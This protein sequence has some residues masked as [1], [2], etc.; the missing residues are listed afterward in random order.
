LTLIISLFFLLFLMFY[1]MNN[2][3]YSNQKHVDTERH[4]N[5]YRARVISGKYWFFQKKIVKHSTISGHDNAIST[6]YTNYKKLQYLIREGS[7]RGNIWFL[8]LIHYDLLEY[9]GL[10]QLFVFVEV[11]FMTWMWSILENVP[12]TSEKK[13]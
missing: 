3:F 6:I 4:F 5:E 9:R 8:I 10:F 11:W 1:L 13:V 12:W 7:R 2:W